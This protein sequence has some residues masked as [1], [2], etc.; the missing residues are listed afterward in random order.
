MT[1]SRKCSPTVLNVLRRPGRFA[2]WLAM[3]WLM[4]SFK[5]TLRLRPSICCAALPP[6]KDQRIKQPSV[7]QQIIS[8][9]TARLPDRLWKIQKSINAFELFRQDMFHAHTNCVRL[10]MAMAM[11]QWQQPDTRCIAT[12]QHNPPAFERVRVEHLLYLYC[13]YC[14]ATL[15]TTSTPRCLYFMQMPTGHNDL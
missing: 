12:I 4:P 13:L 7:H 6:L 3:A 1:R 8:V 11:T 10:A 5:W 15:Y 2:V 14:T 9:E